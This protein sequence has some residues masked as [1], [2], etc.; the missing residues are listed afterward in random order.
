MSDTLNT[1]ADPTPAEP[2][3]QPTNTPTDPPAEPTPPAADNIFGGANPPADTYDFSETCAS[4]GLEMSQEA[5][6]G[7]IA[8]CKEAGIG[9]EQANKL[10]AYGLK[11]QQDA[12][13]SVIAAQIEREKGWANTFREE[14]GK[15]Y[16][17]KLQKIG[18]AKE[19][20]EKLHPGFTQ[21]AID[22]GAGNHPVFL[23]LM[24]RLADMVGEENGTR[25]DNGTAGGSSTMYDKTDFSKYK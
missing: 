15:D 22:T 7:F 19:W 24:A 25:L 11:L 18:I 14:A 16:D 10:A 8:V 23:N 13:D 3:N 17:A 6:D 12:A 9:N 20:A 21:M 5:S 1:P 2:T 4:L